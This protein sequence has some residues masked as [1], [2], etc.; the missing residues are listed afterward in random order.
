MTPPPTAILVM[1]DDQGLARLCQKKLEKAGYRVEVAYDGEAGLAKFHAGTFDA[2]VLDHAMPG[3]DGLEVI[4]RLTLDGLQPAIIMA[5]ASGNERLAVEALQLGARDYLIKDV[6]AGYLD[7]LPTVIEHAIYQQRIEEEMRLAAR[8]FENATEGIFVT[9]ID[10]RIISVNTAFTTITGQDAQ[11][12]VGTIPSLWQSAHHSADFYQRLWTA[13]HE[14]GKWEGELWDSRREGESYPTWHTVSLVNN[15]SAQPTNYIGFLVDITERKR[16]ETR[17]YHLATHDSLTDLPNRSLFYDRMTHAM[18]LARRKQQLLALYLFDLDHFKPINDT[19]GHAVGDEV[20]RQ[21]A[22]RLTDALRDCDTIARLGGDEFT[23][24]MT[25]FTTAAEVSDVAQRIL[26][27]IAEP[28]HCEGQQC[29]LT[30]SIGISI[31]PT[32]SDE[33]DRLLKHADM[34]MYRAK[35]RRNCYEFSPLAATLVG[36]TVSH[37]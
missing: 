4:R 33:L 22:T 26:D 29:R 9:D 36:E 2:V 12:V 37:P 35:E 10:R 1:E 31:Y 32:D 30:A 13:V 6:N 17:L 27:L 15:E 5:T 3:Y 14:S 19:L 18:R 25:G 7:L 8:V 16:A 21:V 23:V 20:L 24:L 28:Y 34:A 11:A